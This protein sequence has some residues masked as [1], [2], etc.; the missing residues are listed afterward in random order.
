MKLLLIGFGGFIGALLRYWVSG[1]IVRISPL[2]PWGTFVV[3]VSGSFALGFGATFM[4]ERLLVSP[5]IRLFVTIGLLG[6][7]TTFSTFEYETLMLLEKGATWGALGNLFG[8]LAAG[9][10][11][12][13]LGRILAQ[14]L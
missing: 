11:A 5:E 4:A 1:L 2:F 8:S 6:A 3:N 10:V 7:Y 13:K 12:V 9:L 14:I